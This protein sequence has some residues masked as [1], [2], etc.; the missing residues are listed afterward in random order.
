MSSVIVTER[1]LSGLTTAVLHRLTEKRPDLNFTNTVE[2]GETVE[3]YSIGFQYDRSGGKL[4]TD[5]TS[6]AMFSAALS[7]VLPNGA[8]ARI[9]CRESTLGKLP[10]GGVIYAEVITDKEPGNPRPQ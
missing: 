10:F 9:I 5:P 3:R 7:E 2:T 8:L 1:R 4:P 6:V